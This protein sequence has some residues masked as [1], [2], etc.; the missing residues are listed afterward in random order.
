MK[1]GYGGCY[2]TWYQFTLY[3]AKEKSRKERSRIEESKRE[4]E[5]SRKYIDFKV[6]GNVWKR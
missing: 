6:Q 5:M 3:L 2:Y 4:N 1:K